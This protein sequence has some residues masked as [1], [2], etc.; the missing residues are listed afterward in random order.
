MEKLSKILALVL[1]CILVL[2][3]A[4]FATDTPDTD[5]ATTTTQAETTTEATTEATTTDV[6]EELTTE[7]TT[8]ETT[9]EEAEE[10][11][12]EATT[13][14]T[15]ADV[16]EESTTETTTEDTTADVTE[17]STT[18]TTSEETTTEVA[19]ESTTTPEEESTTVPEEESTTA[20]DDTTTTT[21]EV[22]DPTEPTE[23]EVTDP[24]EPTEP[25]V[26]EP[27][28]PTEPEVTDPTEPTEPEVTDPTEPTEPEVTDPTEP[29]EPEVELPA[30]PANI[31]ASAFK[32]GSVSVSWDAV[33]NASGYDV[34]LK[35][36]ENWVFQSSVTKT[37]CTLKNALYNS[38]YVMG[39]KTFVLVD[40]EKRES[41]EMAEYTVFT[42]KDIPETKFTVSASSDTITLKWDGIKGVSGYRV[43]IKQGSKWVKLT[44]TSENSYTYK[45]ALPG[46]TYKFAIKPYSKGNEGTKFGKLQTGKVAVENYSKTTVKANDKT[47]STISIKWS[48]IKNAS[49]YRVYIHKN[50]KWTYY[51]GITK[52]TYTIKG[53]KDATN[54]K[55]K[56]KPCFK[57]DGKVTWGSYSDTITVATAGKVLKAHRIEDLK[58]K[59]T[60]D[61]WSVKIG[62][63]GAYAIVAFKNG[64]LCFKDDPLT[65]ESSITIGNK[66]E[67]ETR[68][69]YPEAKEYVDITIFNTVDYYN[70]IMSFNPLVA[71]KV[72]AKTTI[73]NGKRVV[74]EYFKGIDGLRKTFYFDGDKIVGA[75]F[76]YEYDREMIIESFEP[77][78]KPAD[79]MFKFP[80]G[81]KEVPLW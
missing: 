50:G 58:K 53:L 62:F 18:E 20:P 77:L 49:S 7:A 60:K 46:K 48:K 34:Y 39:I 51:K 64:T 36:G 63:D 80:T 13:E 79:S 31:K 15:T 16:T 59:F 45:K 32:N 71:K 52:N 29:T 17:E 40:G 8:E 21:P 9:T 3:I 68:L 4:V 74:A 70:Y 73:F 23:P 27:T 43:Y 81:Y 2:N 76:I 33:E 67:V 55:I 78:G 47:T 22:T 37:K 19:E 24:T 57:V 72:T 25:E 12:T 14:E 6:T 56:V 41:A 65:S 30:M 35:S 26:T 10:S 1:S 11:T 61:N 54:Y 28:E 5:D 69:Y 75:K 42:G 38:K 66:K 44:S